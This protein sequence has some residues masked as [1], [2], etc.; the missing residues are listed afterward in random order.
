MARPRHAQLDDRAWLERQYFELKK[1]AGTIA[2]ELRAPKTTV[3][4][5]LRRHGI[6]LRGAGMPK[7]RAADSH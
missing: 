3:Y 5:A 6:P 7:R 4:D 1:G 2:R